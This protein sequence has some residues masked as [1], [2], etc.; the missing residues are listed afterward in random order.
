MGARRHWG[1][2][3]KILGFYSLAMIALVG[4]N[5]VIQTAYARMA[6]EF[7]VRL[8]R[9]HAI[10]RLRENFDQGYQDLERR[11]RENDPPTAEGHGQEM[12]SLW[13]NFAAAEGAAD[14]SLEAYFNVRATRMGIE[15]YARYVDSA[16][17]LRQAGDRAYYLD[18]VGAGRIASYVDSYL[19]RLLS[20]SLEAGEIKYGDVVRR[21]AALR[22]LTVLGTLVFGVVYIALAILFS[23][24]VAKPIARLAEASARIAAGDLEVGEVAARTGD[25]VESLTNSFNAM[26]RSLREMVEDLRGK[27]ELERRLRE[28]ERELLDAEKALKEAQFMSLQDQIRPHFLFNALNTIARTALFEDAAETGR[29]THALG[30]L[31]RYS[32]GDA[33]SM[34]PVREELAVL[35]EYLQFQALRFGDRLRWDIEVGKGVEDFS[36]PRFTIQPLVENAVR[37][38]IEPLENGGELAVRVTKRDARL[39]IRVSDT[40]IGMESRKARRLLLGEGGGI[41]L[42]NVS[43]RLAL[44]YGPEA[45]IALESAPGRGTVIRIS[46]PADAKAAQS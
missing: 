16:I 41:G 10:H 17:R 38:G 43:R 29:L 23:A 36:I 14:E 46:I 37:H 34:V 33:E 13:V 44:R 1:I 8:A 25:E 31:L 30:R 7:E 32:L 4:V 20:A 35:G 19:S 9:Y 26:S 5:I 12:L 18:L 28:E 27:A 24:S 6:G 2:R 42:S 45:K 22:S 15:A 3:A 21:S 40:G 39:L 11:F